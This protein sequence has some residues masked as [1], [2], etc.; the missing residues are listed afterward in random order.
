MKQATIWLPYPLRQGDLEQYGYAHTMQR[1]EPVVAHV[2]HTQPRAKLAQ[3]PDSRQLFQPHR[4]RS[5]LQQRLTM[6][7]RLNG[8]SFKDDPALQ[9][10]RAESE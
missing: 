8:A 7:R 6:R 10:L 1:G 3:Q 9:P 4:Q 5:Q 2:Q